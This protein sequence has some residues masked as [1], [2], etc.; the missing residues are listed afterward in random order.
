MPLQI[1]ELNIQKMIR[2]NI[3]W[4]IVLFIAL[5]LLNYVIQ[6]RMYWNFKF[7]DIISTIGWFLVAYIALI[8]LHEVCHLIGFMVYGNASFKSLSYGLDL[9]KGM[10]YA[11]T[12]KL[13]DNHAMKKALLLPFWLTGVLPTVY[14][15]YN[16]NYLWITVGALLIAGAVGDFAMYKELRKLPK[17]VVV[18]DDP[19]EPKLYIY[20]AGTKQA[21]LPQHEEQ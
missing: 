5:P 2:Q 13:I 18:K 8:I 9:E 12:T 21:D 4:S 10:A 3:I 7:W 11:T 16:D 15:F 14:G 17:N 1:I 20:P 6:P 19:Q